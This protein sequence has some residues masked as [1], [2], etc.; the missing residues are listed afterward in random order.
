MS[1]SKKDQNILDR[2]RLD[3][4]EELSW[5][6]RN[7]TN[8]YLADRVIKPGEVVGPEHLKIA[9]EV[10]SHLVFADDDPHANFTHACRYL[11]YDAEHGRLHREVQAGVPPTSATNPVQLHPFHEPRGFVDRPVIFR[12]WPPIW[13][14]PILGER[15]RYAILWS[16]MSNRRHLND[17]EFLY[18]TLIDR[19]GFRA[20]H[21]YA[22]SYDG[23][24]NTQDGVQ[25]TWPGDGTAYRI[26]ITGQGTRTDF[27][28]AVDDL[29]SH[30]DSD[31]L[32]L[33]HVNNHGGYGGTPG[34]ATFCTYPS[35]ADYTA[36]DF[37]SKLSELPAHQKLIA[38][39]E[40]CHAGGFNAPILAAS[41]ASST[42]VASAA[43]EP[44]NSYVTADGNWDPFARDWIAAQAGHDAFGAALAYNPDG[45]ADGRIEAEEAYWYADAIKDP[46]DTPNFSESSEAGGDI[47]LGRTYSIWWWWCLILKDVLEPHLH[48]MPPEE[49]QQRL[50]KIE[51]ELKRLA[52]VANHRSDELRR[53][54]EPE[55]KKVIERAFQ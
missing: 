53:E 12:P 14:C 25:S 30:L 31:D 43:L 49:Y 20:N 1:N 23:T 46:R 48:H 37:A 54:L 39:L 51:P 3:V 44:Y 10:A 41:T 5:S 24:L 11:F 21:I 26:Q 47:A 55:L 28:A 34:S 50:H 42:S 18:R 15:Q 2:I 45:D 36:T 17:M 8:L 22:M 4:F 35:W 6:Q 7:S 9:P 29:K 16:G 19:Y 52:S 38:M 32:L 33:I 40:P 27:E 13:R